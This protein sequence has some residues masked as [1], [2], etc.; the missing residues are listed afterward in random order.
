MG[1][2]PRE[3][4][5]KRFLSAQKLVSELILNCQKQ[6]LFALCFLFLDTSVTPFLTP[7]GAEFLHPTMV[8]F[9]NA[10]TVIK[11][12]NISQNCVH[13]QDD[14]L[15]LKNKSKKNKDKRE[16]NVAVSTGN[17]VIY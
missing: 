13:L 10:H 8:Q 3:Q 16:S 5:H 7:W 12:N 6:E 15:Y 4:G 2:A 9:Q 11:S 1:E 17:R 14:N